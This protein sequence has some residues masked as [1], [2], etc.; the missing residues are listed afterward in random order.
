M[1]NFLI[2]LILCLILPTVVMAQDEVGSFE[3]P[4]Y[5]MGSQMFT[6]RAGPVIP[7]F[8]YFP[9][10][11]SPIE[12][13]THMKTG[14]YGSIRYQGFT[15]SQLA[16]GGEL[17]Y[18]FAYS[19]SDLFTSVPVQFSM[20]WIPVQGT[21]ELPISLGLGFAYNSYDQSSYLSMFASFEVGLSW[22]FTDSWG[23]TLSAGYWLI[24]ELYSGDKQADTA[25][26]SMMPIILSVNYRD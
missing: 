24:P 14:G 15:N 1:K 11:N 13:D 4:Q 7:L 21:V 2:V 9:Y 3:L 19:Q 22:Y 17:G 5:Q 20:S 23:I 12:T 26:G 16:L 8:V 25:L 18:Y 10:D 6:F